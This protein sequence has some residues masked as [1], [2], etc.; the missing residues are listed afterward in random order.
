MVVFAMVP[1]TSEAFSSNKFTKRIYEVDVVSGVVFNPVATLCAVEA[2]LVIEFPRQESSYIFCAGTLV[3]FFSENIVLAPFW[4]WI[5]RIVVRGKTW[6]D[7]ICL[8]WEIKNLEDLC[9][10]VFLTNRLK[11][12]VNVS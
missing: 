7:A 1:D 8:C 10:H 11:K 9:I 6:V 5:F 12:S 3:K 4:S 2:R